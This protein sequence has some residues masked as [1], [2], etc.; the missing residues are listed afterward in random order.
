MDKEKFEKMFEVMK[1]CCTDEKGLTNCCAMMKKMMPYGEGKEAEK[2]VPERQNE[3]DFS[4]FFHDECVNFK[5]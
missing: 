3:E 1:G 2:K 4:G 5:R